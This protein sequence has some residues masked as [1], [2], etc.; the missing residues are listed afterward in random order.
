[1]QQAHD[2][3]SGN[4]FTPQTA[5]LCADCRNAH[6][7]QS[8]RGSLFLLCELSRTDP[9]F[10]KYPRLPVLSCL[11]YQAR[12]STRSAGEVIIV[13]Y[14]AAWPQV[15]KKLRVR[16]G[17]VLGDMAAEIE[18]IGS[19]AVPG[20]AAKPIIDVDVLLRSSA[21]MT[22][23]IQRLSDARYEHQGDLGVPEREAF[24]APP[25]DPAHHLYVCPPQSPEYSRHILLRDYLRNHPS[26]AVAY[27]VVKRSLAER[28]RNDRSAYTQGKSEFI[29]SLLR[30]ATENRR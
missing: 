18:H 13:D 2:L 21:D 5:G 29:G 14:D 1:M 3:S 12:S 19:T 4:E 22:L 17:A 25:G 6:N 28:F 20:L 11:A 9:R 27:A 26:D 30:L 8:S 23:A 10:A 24:A 15:F 7:I 16:L